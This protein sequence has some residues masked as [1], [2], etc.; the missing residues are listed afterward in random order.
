MKRKIFIS[1]LFVTAVILSLGAAKPNSDEMKRMGI[2]VS[3]F[4][5]QGLFEFDVYEGD[6]E[7]GRLMHLGDEV[8][9]TE[10]I[11]FG[12][13]HNVI[14]KPKSTVKKCTV[15][16]CPYGDSVMPAK[17][18]SESVKKY[19]D[20]DISHQSENGV[21]PNFHYE[22]GEYHFTRYEWTPERVI[23]ADVQKVTRKGKV[24]T[25]SGE[26]YNHEKKSERLGTFEA[27]A[28]PYKWNNKDTWA[29]LS[30]ISDWY[31]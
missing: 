24:I 9:M 22:N 5:E 29:I 7:D 1:I 4:T 19:F 14:N 12:I 17:S 3:N 25:M 23:Y 31:E 30:L 16:N 28:K 26:L 8:N 27:Q 15:R 21:Y 18:V 10:L 11:R 2:F 6:G 13:Q 20:M